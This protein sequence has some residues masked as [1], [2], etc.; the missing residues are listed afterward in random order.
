MEAF[1][2][3]ADLI[4]GGKLD[5]AERTARDLPVRFP[6]VAD[7]GYRCLSMVYEARGDKKRA[8]DYYRLALAYIRRH[9]P[10]DYLERRIADLDRAEPEVSG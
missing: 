6:D 2:A 8:A 3:V 1:F 10:V 4:R 9:S 7:K 5:E